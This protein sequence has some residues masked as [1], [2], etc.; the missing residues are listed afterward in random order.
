MTNCESTSSLRP[1]V[2]YLR[3]S[4]D[5]QGK[6]GLGLEAQREAIDAFLN[7]NCWELLA[8]FVEIESG[9]KADRPE[10]T[11]ALAACKRH[12]AILVIA[13]LDRLARNVHFVSGLMEAGVEFRCADMP[14]AN[15]TMLQLW[16][17]M[18]E[19]ER[20]QIIKR[21]REAL[22]AAKARG[23]KLGS[24][25]PGKGSAMGV[26]AQKAQ[27]DRFAAN[28]RPVVSEIQAAGVTS[29]RGIADALNARGV[30]TARGGAWHASS[31]RNVLAR[32]EAS[33]LG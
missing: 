22:Q 30:R 31:V 14:E 16:A 21:T 4:T 10:L 27:A 29:L 6:S 32:A 8:E 26:A 15:K 18:A 12:K 7:G 24:P 9:S 13:K 19:W 28:V 1:Y 3:V 11:Q 5:R 20:E 17:V 23:V 2:S 33:L 25:V